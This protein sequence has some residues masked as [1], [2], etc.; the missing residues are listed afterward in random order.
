MKIL[1]YRSNKTATRR[2]VTKLISSLSGKMS[3]IVL[4]L[5]IS[6][7]LSHCDVGHAPGPQQ[8]YIR[9]IMSKR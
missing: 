8:F 6:C 9:L 4:T 3:C 2:F 1:D 7:E 5:F